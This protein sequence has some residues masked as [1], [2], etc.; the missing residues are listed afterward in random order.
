MNRK[1]EILVGVH[2]FSV[3]L[4]FIHVTEEKTR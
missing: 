3:L 1:F 4:N 2:G